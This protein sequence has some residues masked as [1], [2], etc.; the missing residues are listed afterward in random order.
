MGAQRVRP[1]TLGDGEEGCGKKSRDEGG[2]SSSV[3][4]SGEAGWKKRVEKE[5]EERERS[6]GIICFLKTSCFLG[7]A[8]N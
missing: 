5:K 4:V 1:V 6:S 7:Q 8:G 2:G 3:A